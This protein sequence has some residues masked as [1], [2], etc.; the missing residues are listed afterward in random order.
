MT[1]K[2]IAIAVAAFVGIV[3]VVSAEAEDASGRF[4]VYPGSSAATL[5]GTGGGSLTILVDS[6]TG[7]TWQ[8]IREQN[9]VRWDPVHFLPTKMAGD[10]TPLMGGT[11]LP[12]PVEGLAGQH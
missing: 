2:I 12:Q 7:R 1:M 5:Q 11:V 8:L 3:S 9:G 6:K 10:G 4:V